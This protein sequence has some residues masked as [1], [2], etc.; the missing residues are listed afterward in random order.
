MQGITTLIIV[1]L[2]VKHEGQVLMAEINVH[3]HQEHIFEIKRDGRI[4]MLI[5]T[6]RQ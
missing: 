3:K 6:K 4:G 5:R 2:S 1:K